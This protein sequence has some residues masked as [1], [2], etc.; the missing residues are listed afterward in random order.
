MIKIILFKPL[1]GRSI[2]YGKRLDHNHLTSA[3][4]LLAV[5]HWDIVEVPIE[6]IQSIEPVKP[7]PVPPAPRLVREPGLF[8]DLPHLA[9]Y[10]LMGVCVITIIVALCWK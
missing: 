6:L 3:S 1:K 5:G 4:M 10:C 7:V 9:M 8:E 2:L